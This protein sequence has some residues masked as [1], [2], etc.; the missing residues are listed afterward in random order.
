MYNWKSKP[1]SKRVIFFTGAGLSQASGLSTYHDAEGVWSK[2]DLGRVCNYTRF[3]AH[4]EEMFEFFEKAQRT[5]LAASPNPA[6]VYL[7]E[8]MVSRPIGQVLHLTQNVDPLIDQVLESH[9]KPELIGD[10]FIKLHGSILN[11]QCTACGNSWPSTYGAHVR[12]PNCSSL[13]GVKPGVVFYNEAAPEYRKIHQLQ[14]T[15]RSSNDLIV[16]IGTQFEI[17]EP[18]SILPRG[19]EASS[20]VNVNPTL[21]SDSRIGIHIQKPVVEALPELDDLVQRW[22]K[23]S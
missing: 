15:L 18:N 20:V 9:S 1:V 4:R 13:K 21:F 12:C 8:L 11:M 7:S 16:F 19:F 2:Y 23:D 6:H 14:K 17:W 22:L 10:T 5:M 3:K